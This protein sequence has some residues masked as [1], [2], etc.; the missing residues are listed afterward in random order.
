MDTIY[1]VTDVEIDGPTPGKNS[2]MSFASVAT[3]AGGVEIDVFE[4]VLAPLNGASPDPLTIEWFQSQPEA[5]AAATTN[6]QAP[7]EVMSRYVSWIRNLQ[8]KPI[9]TSH[10]L[11]LDGPWIDFYLQHFAGTKLLEGPWIEG[12][13]FYD[14]EFCLKSFAAGRLGWPLSRCKPEHYDPAWMG[15]QPHTHKAIDDA[16][17]Y[18]NLLRYLLSL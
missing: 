13:L 15:N 17:G 12:R 10:P 5:L 2:M 4:A 7:E 16:R 9:F 18:A 14:A 11:A 1:I 8:G 3:N 6:P